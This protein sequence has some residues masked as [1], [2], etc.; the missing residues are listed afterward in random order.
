MPYYG[1]AP[2]PQPYGPARQKNPTE[3]VKARKVFVGGIGGATEQD[4]YN[5]F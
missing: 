4:I 2:Q 3:D 5:Y 1:T